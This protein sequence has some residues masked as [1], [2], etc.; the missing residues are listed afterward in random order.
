MIGKL[1]GVAIG[2][3][4][5]GIDF[6]IKGV[7]QYRN[8]LEGSATHRSGVGTAFGIGLVRHFAE[9]EKIRLA[10][11]RRKRMNGRAPG[12]PESHL[13]MLDRIDAVAVEA[14]LLDPILVYL[15]HLSSDIVRLSSEIIQAAQ[16]AQFNLSGVL[17]ILDIALV[18]KT[19]GQRWIC[20][21]EIEGRGIL[22]RGIT[23]AQFVTRRRILEGRIT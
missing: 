17:V 18:V 19:V 7:I 13:H 8:E 20:G 10:L 14:S 2:A 6:E 16:F 3:A 9:H 23:K 11:R 21:V 15:A 5:D 22:P 4:K 12:L 1:F